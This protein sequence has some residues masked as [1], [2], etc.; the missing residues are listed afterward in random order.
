MNIYHDIVPEQQR[1]SLV[2]SPEYQDMKMGQYLFWKGWWHEE[3][4]DIIQETL[5]LMWKGK[6]DEKKYYNGGIEYWVNKI[7]GEHYGQWHQD[8]VET[9]DDE[10]VRGRYYI[11]GDLSMVYYPYVHELKGGYLELAD[12]EKP[13]S[14]AD[15]RIWLRKLD[16]MNIERIKPRQGSAVL[17]NSSRVHRVAP[18]YSGRRDA[19]A[20][21]IWTNTP[22]TF[23]HP[24]G[25]NPN[26][27][28]Y[29]ED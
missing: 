10:N 1:I 8:I 24:P 4:N 5:M 28:R 20:S 9:D 7:G 21:T 15:F 11:P 14:K 17:Y 29:D 13:V 19:L 12:L 22:E 25:V 2:K 26:D 18:V 27:D 3:P 23:K 16:P 6:V